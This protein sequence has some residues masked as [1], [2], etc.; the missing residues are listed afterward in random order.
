MKEVDEDDDGRDKR[1]EEGD[2]PLFEK[3][4]DPRRAGAIINEGERRPGSLDALPSRSR[5]LGLSVAPVEIRPVESGEWGRIF[6]GGEE[7]SQSGVQVG[8]RG[9]VTHLRRR[10]WRLRLHMIFSM[11]LIMSGSD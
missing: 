1:I 5:V 9:E 6:L 4:G 10:V 8:E 7:K 11:C 3:V 2:P